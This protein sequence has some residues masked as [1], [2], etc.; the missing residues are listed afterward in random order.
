MEKLKEQ[1][2]FIKEKLEGVKKELR[3]RKD[4]GIKKRK[5]AGR[6]MELERKIEEKEEK[7]EKDK[8]LRGEN[9][10]ERDGLVYK[11]KGLERRMELREKEVRKKNVV[12]R[13][14]GGEKRRRKEV[15]DYLKR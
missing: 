4:N 13:G 14:M 10:G 3:E 15:M 6:I 11:L 12:I 2:R 8:E 9:E 5:M 7:E 1:R